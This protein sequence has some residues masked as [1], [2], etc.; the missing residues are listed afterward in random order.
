MREVHVKKISLN[1]A[2]RQLDSMVPVRRVLAGTG[3]TVKLVA[4]VIWVLL[5]LCGPLPLRH[6][7]GGQ[8]LAVWRR[9]ITTLGVETDASRAPRELPR[10]PELC[11]VRL[12]DDLGAETLTF[13][14]RHRRQA[15][16]ASA[17]LLMLSLL[18][19]AGQSDCESPWYMRSE[20][21]L[22]MLVAKTKTPTVYYVIGQRSTCV[23]IS[24]VLIYI[25]SNIVLIF[26]M[27][28]RCSS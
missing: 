10:A 25:H 11:S 4:G 12:I 5:T 19:T 7:V 8:L 23:S 17:S 1:T 28:H 2:A 15:V 20:R 3:L 16:V 27:S 21:R 26:R 18:W 13:C 6:A 14:S 9:R 22:T 24:N